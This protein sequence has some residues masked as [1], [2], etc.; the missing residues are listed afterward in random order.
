MRAMSVDGVHLHSMTPEE[1]YHARRGTDWS[2]EAVYSRLR[3]AGLD[4]APGT[5]A[6]ILVDEVREVVCPGK[7]TSADWLEAMEGAMAAGLDTTATIMYGHVETE[8]HRAMHLKRVRDLQDRTGGITEF[9]PLSFVHENTPLYKHG[10][11]DGGASDAEDELM[12]AVSRLF[13]DNIDNIQSSWVKYGNAKGLKLLNC[14]A[15][16]FMGTI[17]SEEIT[18]RA[19][20]SY[21]EFRSVADYVDMISAIGRRP[22]ERST[23]YRTKQPIEIDGGPYGPTLGPRADG[24][25]ML[26]TEASGDS[27]LS[28]DD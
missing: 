8:M 4:T 3:E 28:A 1:A 20:G 10:V 23:D 27:R 12:I 24:T 18:K 5:A 17:L 15:N 25:P 13:F 19:G 26:S 9:V 14:G 16:D 22:V 7:I 6:E 21:G 11:V 2:Y